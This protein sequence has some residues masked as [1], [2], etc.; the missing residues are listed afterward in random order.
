MCP[1]VFILRVVVLIGVSSFYVL[2]ICVVSGLVFGMVPGGR[3][4]LLLDL[5]K[6]AAL[7]SVC[8]VF[9]LLAFNDGSLL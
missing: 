9:P 4:P 6:P 8:L 1:D 3:F 2:L 5:L 7:V